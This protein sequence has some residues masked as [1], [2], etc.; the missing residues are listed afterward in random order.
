MASISLTA[1]MMS[2]GGMDRPAHEGQQHRFRPALGAP[3]HLIDHLAVID[4]RDDKG[5][6][7]RGNF[8][9]L[10]FRK[11]PKGDQTQ[12]PDFFSGLIGDR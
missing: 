6:D 2:C 11:R 4:F 9:D 3:L 1:S 5:L 10:F 8:P 12:Q 7:P